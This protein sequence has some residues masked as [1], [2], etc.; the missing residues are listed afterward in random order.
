[1]SD[2][3]KKIESLQH[4]NINRL[5]LE[6][7][8]TIQEIKWA[9]KDNQSRTDELEARVKAYDKAIFQWIE[10]PCTKNEFAVKDLINQSQ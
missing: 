2:L 4:R 3:I 10:N 9:I 7:S 6:D 5:S 8:Q 1:M